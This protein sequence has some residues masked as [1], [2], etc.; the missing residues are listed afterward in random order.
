MS[1]IQ[2]SEG[3]IQLAPDLPPQSGVERFDDA[4][5]VAHARVWVGMV[6]LLVAVAG[7]VVWAF[8]AQVPNKVTSPGFAAPGG[9]L[10]IVTSPIDG[11]IQNLTVKAG[12]EVT[13]GQVVGT[14]VD[15]QDK[16]FPLFAPAGGIVAAMIRDPGDRVT[17]D[18]PRVVAIARLVPT[19]VQAFVAPDEASAGLIQPG[20]DAIVTTSRGALSGTVEYVD[21]LPLTDK[22]V[23]DKIGLA[24]PIPVLVPKWPVKRAVIR[25]DNQDVQL[26]GELVQVT[27]VVASQHPYQFVFGSGG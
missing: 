3:N 17:I 8:V 19:V 6:G 25:L 18:S 21:P 5:V 16:P 26:F 15:S 23:E 14:V 24:A 1:E 4:I 20:D 12:D 22:H 11:T 13:E 27:I 9:A 10:V 7:L 2:E